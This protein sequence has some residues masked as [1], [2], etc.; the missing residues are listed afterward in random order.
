M[1]TSTC[2]CRQ[3]KLNPLSTQINIHCLMTNQTPAFLIQRAARTRAAVMLLQ[4]LYFSLKIKIA[5]TVRSGISKR[6][7]EKWR[8]VNS[9]STDVPFCCLISLFCGVYRS[10]SLQSF[11]LRPVW[12]LHSSTTPE[13]CHN[14]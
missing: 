12:K 3:L 2:Q 4:S 11:V 7:H 10:M 5:V 9:L 8:A 6:S 1:E 14:S 13:N